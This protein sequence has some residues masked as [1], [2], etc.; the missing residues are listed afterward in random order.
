MPFGNFNFGGFPGQQ[1]P[2]QPGDPPQPPQDVKPKKK[3]GGFFKKL[4]GKAGIVVLVA[5]LAVCAMDAFYSINEQENAVVVTFGKPQAVT[6]SGLHVKIPFIQQVHKVD[7][8]IHGF[9][10]GYDPDCF[11]MNGVRFDGN[12]S[13]TFNPEVN[14][15][16]TSFNVD[17]VITGWT[18]ALLHMNKGTFAEVYIPYQMAYKETG[19]RGVP[20]YSVLKFEIFLNDVMHPKGPDDRSRKMQKDVVD[21]K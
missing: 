11:L 16:F 18:T 7:M 2:F 3:G 8:T 1:N 10:I 12:Y 4:A 14:D 20:G 17:R 15:N 9:A 13:G 5:A 6:S 21:L 19:D